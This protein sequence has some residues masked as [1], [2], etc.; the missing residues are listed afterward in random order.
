MDKRRECSDDLSGHFHASQS[1]TPE[2]DCAGLKAGA[3]RRNTQLICY[4]DRI[5]HMTTLHSV[6]LV[7]AC[8]EANA[9]KLH[10]GMSTLL[11]EILKVN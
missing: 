9:P 3:I 5:A 10:V 8:E 7:L 11:V 2:P 4:L 1:C 6:R